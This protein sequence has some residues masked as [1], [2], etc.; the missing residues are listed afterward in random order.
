MGQPSM[1]DQVAFLRSFLRS[2]ALAVLALLGPMDGVRVAAA[3]P[4][5]AC[6]CCGAMTQQEACGCTTGKPDLPC[7]AKPQTAISTEARKTTAEVS[8]ERPSAPIRPS[9][10]TPWP[11]HVWASIQIIA[12]SAPVLRRWTGHQQTPPNLERLAYLAVFLI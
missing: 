3:Q 2:I 9:E 1:R 4:A 10:P 5:Q 12:P 11:A 7:H 8:L 6:Q